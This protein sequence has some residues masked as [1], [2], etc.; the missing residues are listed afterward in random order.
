MY[1]NI[2]IYNIIC[3]IQLYYIGIC[4]IKY[5][6]LVFMIGPGLLANTGSA[7][8]VRNVSSVIGIH[9]DRT[10]TLENLK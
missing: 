9:I 2:V 7:Y 1:N 10:S 5:H 6:V 3:N 8:L 4:S